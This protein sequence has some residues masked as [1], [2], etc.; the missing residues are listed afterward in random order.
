MY[1][2]LKMTEYLIYRYLLYYAL[3]KNE[4][5]KLCTIF[6]ELISIAI[7]NIQS[8]LCPCSYDVLLI[9]TDLK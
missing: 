9:V 5:L 4:Y 3:Y 1:V 6:L 2:K 8:F 7:Y